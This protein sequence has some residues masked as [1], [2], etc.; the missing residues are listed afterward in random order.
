MIVR[1]IRPEDD[2]LVAAVIRSSLTEFGLNR[3]GTVYY[4]ESTDHLYELFRKERSVYYVALEHNEIIGGAG[5][6]PS[7][8]LPEGVCELVKMYLKP[9]A[10]GRG[11]GRTLIEK[12]LAFAAAHGYSSVYL[13]TM[14]ELQQAVSVYRK[15]GFSYL[16]KAMGNT[17]HYGCEVW[18]LKK[19]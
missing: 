19:L 16:D 12:C 14:P 7:E 8:G 3:P 2:A 6:Y 15:F 1:T 13:E 17:G 11:W 5:I 10:R 18:M 4:D 9:H